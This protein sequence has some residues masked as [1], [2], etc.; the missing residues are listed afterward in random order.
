MKRKWISILLAV[1]IVF[2][3]LSISFN[4]EN[5]VEVNLS[6]ADAADKIESIEPQIEVEV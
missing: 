5:H 1:A 6:S 4:K 2:T 3:P